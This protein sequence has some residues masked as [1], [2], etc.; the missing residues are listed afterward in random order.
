MHAFGIFGDV[1]FEEPS[2]SGQPQDGGDGQERCAQMLSGEEE[3]VAGEMLR[4]LCAEDSALR[5]LH[6]G[7]DA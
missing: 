1:I 6:T 4:A 5:Q 7:S 3:L 2:G